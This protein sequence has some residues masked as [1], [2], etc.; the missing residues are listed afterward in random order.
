MREVTK[1]I[2]V[3]KQ[4]F[5]PTKV[6]AYCRVSTNSSD[7]RNSYATQIRVYTNM[8]N[9]NPEWEL[10][11]VFADEGISGTAADKRDEFMRMI[12]MCEL[13]KIDLIIT[14]SVS[15]FARN[16]KETLEYVRK[17]KLLGVGVRFEKEG[18]NALSLGDE[19]LLNTFSAIVLHLTFPR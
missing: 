5:L 15:R 11:E 8:I 14:K 19:M 6:A 18:I 10:V 12:H 17:L 13:R 9:G 16:V 4:A 1:I 3:G 7:Q 2:P